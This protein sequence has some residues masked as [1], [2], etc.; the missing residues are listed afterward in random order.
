MRRILAGMLACWLA[1]FPT[2][3]AAPCA[4]EAVPSAAPAAQEELRLE[5]VPRSD[6][7]FTSVLS[8]DVVFH[9]KVRGARKL[10][11]RLLDPAGRQTAF[12]TREKADRGYQAM[13]SASVALREGQKWAYD[14]SVVFPRDLQA[15]QW[16]IEVTASA[17]GR[18]DAVCALPVEISDPR[19]LWMSRLKEVHEMLLGREGGSAVPVEPGKIRY[20]AQNPKDSLFVR[21]YWLSKGFDLREGANGKCTRAVFSM[22]LSWLGIDCTPVG[23]SD[24]LRSEELFYTYDQVCG[25]LGNV[26]R[27]EGDLETLW[28]AYQVGEASP[29]L[30]HFVYSGGMHAVLLAARDEAD[31]DLFYAIT[32]GQ[33]VNTSAFP[34]GCRRDMVIPLLIERGEKGARIQSPLLSAYHMGRIDEVWQWKLR[35][36]PS[37]T[38][39]ES[40]ADG[41]AEAPRTETN[42]STGENQ[43]RED[44]TDGL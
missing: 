29:V 36:A 4:A 2:F 30:V 7:S 25:A 43:E 40:P 11:I 10:T 21:E 13:R 9:A 3:Q 38:P 16:T 41:E 5:L 22:A 34:D 23:M 15:G 33:R 26:T 6:T 14:L 31:P 17:E 8:H 1:A 27:V 24:L 35:D 39:G 32:S 28:T 20:I 12:R 37:R 19:P 18:E 42:P 44:M